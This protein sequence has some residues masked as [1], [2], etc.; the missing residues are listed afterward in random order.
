MVVLTDRSS[1]GASSLLSRRVSPAFDPGYWAAQ[2]SA[3]VEGRV[4]NRQLVD[5][6]PQLELVS[7]AVAFVATVTAALLVHRKRSTLGRGRTVDWARSVPLVPRATAGL[8]ADLVQDLLHRDLVAEGVEV[9]TC[10][11]LVQ[12]LLL[13]LQALRARRGEKSKAAFR[14]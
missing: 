2:G 5:C 1:T 4:V 8:E 13:R 7:L 3:Q 11:D 6:C 12:G 14:F 9:D 10:H